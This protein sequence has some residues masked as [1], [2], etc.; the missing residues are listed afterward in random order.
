MLDNPDKELS[1]SYYSSY[2]GTFDK[3]YFDNPC[4]FV[5]PESQVTYCEGKDGGIM[6]KGFRAAFVR[7]LDF[8]SA[9]YQRF[10]ET[11]TTDI[12]HY[13][14]EVNHVDLILAEEMLL[15]IFVYIFDELIGVY[16]EDLYSYLD[17][18][19]GIQVLKFWIFI[20]FIIFLYAF[21]WRPFVNNLK[22]KIWRTQSML[23]MIP[24]A[25]I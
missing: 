17:E 18:A 19:K 3:I 2:L 10:N 21:V 11:T 16:K 13:Y 6:L 8:L 7:N 4:Q 23:Q 22:G 5:M 20:V 1:R 25:I 24:V 14:S 15:D 12:T 9:S